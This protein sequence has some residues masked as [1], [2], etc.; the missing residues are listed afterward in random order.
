MPGVKMPTSRETDVHE[1]RSPAQQPGSGRS[2]TGFL[3][4]I[5]IVGAVVALAVLFWAAIG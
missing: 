5:V 3:A 2:F 1:E 4:A